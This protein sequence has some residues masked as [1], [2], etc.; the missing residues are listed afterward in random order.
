MNKD[1]LKNREKIDSIDNQ[2]FDLLMERLD[3][4]TTIGYIKKR[5]RSSSVRSK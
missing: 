3:A 4:V 5:T 1:I 2:I